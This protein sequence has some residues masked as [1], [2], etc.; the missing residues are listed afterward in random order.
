MSLGS[1]KGLGERYGSVGHLCTRGITSTGW[2]SDGM[3]GRNSGAKGL[4]KSEEPPTWS[5]RWAETRLDG[6]LLSGSHAG[7]TTCVCL[8][9]A[10]SRASGGPS[11]FSAGSV[12]EPS[13]S[14]CRPS[15]FPTCTVCGKPLPMRSWLHY[16]AL[17]ARLGCIPPARCP[18]NRAGPQCLSVLTETVR[19]FR[20][21]RKYCQKQN[22]LQG[23]GSA[24][25]KRPN[26]L[27]FKSRA[28]DL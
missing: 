19:L 26:C 10:S 4:G 1:G 27:C 2:W 24:R 21:S 5:A 6:E 3:L 20:S 8:S 12:T 9:W 22:G 15:T 16:R 23:A 28:S 25:T 11:P 18:G 17:H 13:V 7:V 14:C